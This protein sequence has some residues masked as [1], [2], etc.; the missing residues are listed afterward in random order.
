MCQRYDRRDINTKRKHFVWSGE[1]ITCHRGLVRG[2][3][4]CRNGKREANYFISNCDCFSNHQSDILFTLALFFIAFTHPFQFTKPWFIY[5]CCTNT[6]ID[7]AL[8][9]KW[10]W[11]NESNT[12]IRMRSSVNRE[13]ID[14]GRFCGAQTELIYLCHNWRTVAENEKSKMICSPLLL[15]DCAV[16]MIELFNRMERMREKRAYWVTE[17]L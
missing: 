13:K 3:T 2:A 9:L 17:L 16:R 7:V 12:S 15:A 5:W 8:N 4:V 11:L 14:N 1:A 6:S 10:R